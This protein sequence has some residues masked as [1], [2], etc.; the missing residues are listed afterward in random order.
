[1]LNRTGRRIYYDVI[2]GDLITD[3]GEKYGSVKIT[4]IEQD[5]LSFK[6]LSERN[7]ET[8]DVLELPYGAYAQDF[9]TCNG[10][11]VNPETKG[12]EFIYPDPNE[13][14]AEPVYQKPLSEQIEELEAILMYDSMMK[15]M[16]IEESKNNHAELLYQLM[17][18]GV[19]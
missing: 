12:L 1:M 15:E 3:T 5:I 18:N 6:S 8:F 2:T 9:A 10:Y 14:E 17:I 16:E 4:T 11:R 13:P 19:L 7:R